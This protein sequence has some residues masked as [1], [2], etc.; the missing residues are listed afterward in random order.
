LWIVLC[1]EASPLKIALIGLEASIP[2]PHQAMGELLQLLLKSMHHGGLHV[3]IKSG[4]NASA[5]LRTHTWTSHDEKY[6][7]HMSAHGAR[8]VPNSTGHAGM[9]MVVQHHI[10]H[11]HARHSPDRM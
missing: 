6:L 7:G 10:L 9:G 5:T 11:Q 3:F 8:Q 4:P 2:L 1:K